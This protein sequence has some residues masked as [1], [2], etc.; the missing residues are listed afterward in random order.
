M[1][2]GEVRTLV[3]FD[4]ADYSDFRQIFQG[5]IE[6]PQV[7]EDYLKIRSQDSRK[8][9]LRNITEFSKLKGISNDHKK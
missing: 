8:R 7:S 5:L 3:G 6:N 4:G 1:Y 2:G 9:L